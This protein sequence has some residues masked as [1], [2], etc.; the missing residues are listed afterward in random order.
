MYVA[1]ARKG[2]VLEL[3]LPSQRRYLGYLN[4]LM[5]GVKGRMQKVAIRRVR[6]VGWKGWRGGGSG[7]GVGRTYLQIFKDG[8][9]VGTMMGREGGWTPQGCEITFSPPPP[10]AQG[11][12]TEDLC[13]E[14]D[15]LMRVRTVRHGT[16]ARA[17]MCRVAFHCGFVKFES[18]GE[19]CVTIPRDGLDG[20][21]GWEEGGGMMVDMRNGGGGGEEGYDEELVE[22]W[23]R[24][25]EEWKGRG[26]EG[27]RRK[28]KEVTKAVEGQF[29]LGGGGRKKEKAAAKAEDEDEDEDE[30]ELM[31]EL[32]RVGEEEEEEE[33]VVFE[34]GDDGKLE[35]DKEG[36]RGQQQARTAPPARAEH[37]EPT[38]PPP[39]ASTENCFQVNAEE[40]DDDDDDDDDGDDL[41]AKM[42]ALGIGAGDGYGDDDD[43][44]DDDD[45]GNL[46]D[47]EAYFKNS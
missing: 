11:G 13:V 8:D 31:K 4:K 9:L 14:G 34:G 25:R 21:G 24:V 44:D 16:G 46:D 43:D 3:T 17:S 15:V 38:P 29:S 12:K 7:K 2:S 19:T 45:L 10:S 27:R 42:D 26:L 23:C 22:E 36:D 30:D 41:M 35:K 32:G 39:P 28:G 40:D 47:L 5:V 20:A 37:P 18:G 1:Q 6:I 33:E